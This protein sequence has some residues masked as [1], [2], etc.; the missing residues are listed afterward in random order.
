MTKTLFTAYSLVRPLGDAQIATLADFTSRCRLAGLDL[1]EVLTLVEYERDARVKYP[2]DPLEGVFKVSLPQD[3]NTAE[4]MQSLQEDLA[5]VP[6]VEEN[7]LSSVNE[8]E[9]RVLKDGKVIG[10]IRVCFKCGKTWKWT[11]VRFFASTPRPRN[12]KTCLKTMRG[13]HGRKILE[14]IRLGKEGDK[15]AEESEQGPGLAA[16]IEPEV[17]LEEPSKASERPPD[18]EPQ[19]EQAIKPQKG[20]P[21][22]SAAAPKVSADWLEVM[23]ANNSARPA[24]PLPIESL[25]SVTGE[26]VCHKCGPAKVELDDTGATI[27]ST[28]R[29]R[30]VTPIAKR[31]VVDGQRVTVLAP[32][33]WDDQALDDSDEP[34]IDLVGLAGRKL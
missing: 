15:A 30:S 9:N 8:S 10:E 34:G 7:P 31:G 33:G 25:T 28:C 27:C 32:P 4:R 20:R 21:V 6:A 3:A 24:Q 18:P 17:P 1:L 23:R 14:R 12:C 19:T 5:T 11:P 2:K 29:N 13:D 26:F 16:R 22:P